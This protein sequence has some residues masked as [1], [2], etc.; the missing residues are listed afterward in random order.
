MGT[1]G[2]HRRE[3]ELKVFVRRILAPFECLAAYTQ[4]LLL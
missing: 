4:I 3:Q 2:G 1:V